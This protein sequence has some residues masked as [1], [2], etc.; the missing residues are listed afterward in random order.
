M[1]YIG[2]KR[3]SK[4]K[5]RKENTAH[6]ANNLHPRWWERIDKNNQPG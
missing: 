1:P 5:Q 6:D 2:R 4:E 3:R